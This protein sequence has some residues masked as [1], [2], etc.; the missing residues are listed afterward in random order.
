M[1]WLPLAVGSLIKI[2]YTARQFDRERQVA[3]LLVDRRR[4][5]TF[6]AQRKREVLQHWKEHWGTVH[7]P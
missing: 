6:L 3:E 7:P 2:V 5:E 1:E 4:R